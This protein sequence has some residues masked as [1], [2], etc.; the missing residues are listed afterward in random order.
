M[1]QPCTIALVAHDGKK[2]D[3]LDW[4]RVYREQLAEHNL[5]AT[6]TTGK[7]ISKVTGLQVE[8]MLSGP[9]GGDLQLGTRIAEGAVDILIFF[10]DPLASQPHDPD[11]KALLRIAAVWDVAV[12]TNRATADFLMSSPLLNDGYRRR[13]P[14]FSAHLTRLDR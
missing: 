13:P 8:T 3:L 2:D 1:G 12:A 4:V 9:L 14:D 6:G 10:W 11:V 5:L 7:L